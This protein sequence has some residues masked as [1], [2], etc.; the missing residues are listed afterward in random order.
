ML[1]RS[2]EMKERGEIKQKYQ[3]VW[4][5]ANQAVGGSRSGRVAPPH[6]RRGLWSEALSAKANP[7]D[8]CNH[9]RGII[10]GLAVQNTPNNQSPVI[11]SGSVSVGS[12]SCCRFAALWGHILILS[13]VLVQLS[14]V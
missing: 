12:G 9:R 8:S 5:I 4:E 1:F 2:Q 3:D 6:P 13:Q 14:A 7:V 11:R 10:L